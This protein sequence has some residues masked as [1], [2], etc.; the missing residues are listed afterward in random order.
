MTFQNERGPIGADQW[1]LAATSNYHLEASVIRRP[2]GAPMAADQDLFR[3]MADPYDADGPYTRQTTYTAGVAVGIFM[4][5]GTCRRLDE[6][7][8]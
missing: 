8:R 1:A 6:P 3:Y 2:D 7:W 5:V 4:Q